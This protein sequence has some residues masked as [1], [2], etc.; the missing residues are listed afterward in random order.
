M[1]SAVVLPTFNE[2][3]NLREMVQALLALPV[4]LEILIVDDDSPDGTGAL[5][6][7]CARASARVRVIRNPRRLGFGPSLVV[8]FTEA[9]R[10]GRDKI[11]QMDADFSHPVSAVPVI[12]AALDSAD[13]VIGSR[14]MEGGS[15]PGW[16]RR[17]RALSRGGNWYARALLGIPCADLTAGFKGWR[18]DLLRAIEAETIV[19]GGY[20]FQIESVYR[21]HRLNARIREIPIAFVDRERGISKMNWKIVSEAL[22]RV[23]QLRAS[24]WRPRTGGNDSGAR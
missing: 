23:P 5:A 10:L 13:L 11:L 22:L 14:Y 2:S 24:A 19:A 3:E 12:V 7:E 4:E 16:S 6:E 1:S 18:A 9:L 20:S 17:R 15:T 8:G 21:A